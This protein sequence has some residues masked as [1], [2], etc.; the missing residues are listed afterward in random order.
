MTSAQNRS[1]VHPPG[2]SGHDVNGFIMP[3]TL[4]DLTSAQAVHEAM[5]EFDRLGRD[6]FL[7][8]YGF[9]H[10]REYFVR[11]GGVLYD[12]KAI[13]GVAVGYQF[14]HVGPL[15][16]SDFSGGEATVGAKLQELGFEV[17]VVRGA[18][19]HGPPARPIA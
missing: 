16:S 4:N 13:A 6:A 12:S 1:L 18:S 5:D 9:G 7:A 8:R 17:V 11:R 15:K 3:I 19:E 10:A 14:F 2:T